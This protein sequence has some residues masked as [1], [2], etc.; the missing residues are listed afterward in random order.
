MIQIERMEGIQRVYDTGI[1]YAKHRYLPNTFGSVLYVLLYTALVFALT[2][3][4][5]RGIITRWLYIGSVI[6]V[7]SM[8]YSGA[9][10][11]DHLL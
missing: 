10:T 8:V 1:R 7:V 11:T 3:Y 2:E 4:L 9:I 5:M 6:M